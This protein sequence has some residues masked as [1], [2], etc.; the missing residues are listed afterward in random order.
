MTNDFRE[1]VTAPRRSGPPVD[2]A[3]TTYYCYCDH[4]PRI[5]YTNVDHTR[6]ANRS[7]ARS[8][9]DLVVLYH[10]RTRRVRRGRCRAFCSFGVHTARNRLTA[11]V[12]NIFFFLV[13]TSFGEIRELR[14]FHA[15]RVRNR[16][17]LCARNTY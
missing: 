16:P 11:T 4:I 3:R 13:L 8:R 10:G 6:S 7:P 5:G 9:D 12:V 15:K 14:V 1:I 17:R 2:P